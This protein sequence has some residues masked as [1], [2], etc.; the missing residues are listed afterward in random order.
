MRRLGAGYK[1][2]A[3]HNE[4][5]LELLNDKGTIASYLAEILSN[6]LKPENENPF[7]FSDELNSNKI[8][9]F[10]IKTNTLVFLIEIS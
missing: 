5:V 9:D 4:K 8:N 10:L 3:G 6:P 1:K 7:R 2:T